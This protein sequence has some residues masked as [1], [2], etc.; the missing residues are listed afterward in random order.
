[1]E[2]RPYQ[3]ELVDKVREAWLN[4]ARRPCIV[5]GC[6]GGKSLIA[7][8]MAKRAT[9]RAKRVLFLVHRREL[10]DQITRTFRR[11]GVDMR[12]CRVGMVQTLC[13][14]L[15]K[16]HIPELILIDEC[17]HAL[18]ASYLKV[19]EAFPEARCV[20]ITA[21][22]TRLE[23]GGLGRVFH[24]L[25]QGPSTKWLIEN[26]YLAP[27]DYFSPSV[28]DLSGLTVRRGEF[29]TE[30]VESR[31]IKKAVFGD[32]IS[33]YRRLADGV[34]AI[35]YC[36]S[37]AHSQRM[38]EAF[39]EAGIPAAYIDGK[40]PDIIRERRIADFRSG[41]IQILC[42]VDLISEGFDVPDCGASIL[43]RPTQSL[44]LYIQQAMRCMRFQAGKR[45]IILDHVGN[46]ARFGLPDAD[47]EWSLK[48]KPKGK[49]AAK[50]SD[51]IL[52]RQCPK[53]YYTHEPGPV[54]PSC[55]YA[56]PIKDRTPEEIHEAH[57]E[58]IQGFVLDLTTPD[59]C[60]S[61]EELLAY[62]A[63]KGYKPGWAFYQA[64]QRGL[65][66]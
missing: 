32:V 41:A 57:L 56:Y 16:L 8:D 36:A 45:A 20:G 64:K 38:A 58:K 60:H 25:L 19:L 62:A 30:E 4:G 31:L 40:T 2:L 11:Y 33:Y 65:L 42:N 66:P 43:L 54:C 14:R 21:T 29:V 18:A 39:T 22:P 35:C 13:R 17:H 1:M 37:I 24:Q 52:V 3:T 61:Y 51:D 26:G 15:D 49:R 12:F 50:E 47:R 44:T 5:L 9:A 63:N 55:G 59:D 6:G 53:C 27:Y 48:E 28:A 23:S 10:C 46:Y 34:K 7:A